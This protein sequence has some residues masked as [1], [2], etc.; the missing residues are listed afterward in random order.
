[1]NAMVQHA[2]FWWP[3]DDGHCHVV[4]H[5]EVPDLER[6]LKH[7]QHRRLAIQA[8]G[9]VGIWARYLARTFGTVLTF[10]PD[11]A[12]FDCLLR[13]VPD[14]VK[15]ERAGLGDK[16]CTMGLHVVPGNCGAHWMT[17]DG[18][19]PV[20]TIDSLCLDACDFM[21][22]DLEGSE[23]MALHGAMA[24]IARFRPVIMMEEKGLSEKYYGVNRGAAERWLVREH[25]YRI[26]A[27]VRADVILAPK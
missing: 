19:I 27:R 2:G 3:A 20:V 24:T 16:A 22:L 9:N 4:I 10:E 15:A 6:A 21:A 7:V 25:D 1:M 11:A 8:G 23:P 17:P 14:N 13:N 18:D 12:N 5:K 26:V